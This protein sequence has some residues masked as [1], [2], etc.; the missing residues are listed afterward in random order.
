MKLKLASKWLLVSVLVFSSTTQIGLANENTAEGRD[1]L[2]AIV[3]VET[4]E[5]TP[6]NYDKNSAIDLLQ[7][8]E[9]DR[10]RDILCKGDDPVPVPSAEPSPTFP[11][12]PPISPYPTYP[13][14][15]STGSGDF[16]LDLILN[17]AEKLWQIIQ[18]GRPTFTSTS[19]M[20]N[21]LPEGA[22]SAW[23]LQGWVGTPRVAVYKIR[24]KNAFGAEVGHYSYRLMFT[25]G[26]N[27]HGKGRYLSSVKVVPDSVS[28]PWGCALDAKVDVVNTIALGDARNPTAQIELLVSH[29]LSSY[30][31]TL[32][33]SQSFLVKGDGNYQEIGGFKGLR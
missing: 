13:T 17:L 19:A 22:R 30:F 24:F 20:A 1:P 14:W 9:C 29:S 26:G 10:Q 15:P 3:S 32:T 16:R 21:A 28:V 7:N 33:G 25:Y 8:S 4:V 12:L 27:V 5:L 6:K 31:K 23:D 18:D 2:D 11:P